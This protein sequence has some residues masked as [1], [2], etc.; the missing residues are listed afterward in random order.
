M[1]RL[2]S[3]LT[4][5]GLGALAM[6]FL[7]PQGGNRR[8]ALLRDQAIGFANRKQAAL[9]VMVTDF[10]NRAN[11]LMHEVQAMREQE[12]PDDQTLSER[13]RAAMGRHVSHPS[14][15]DVSSENGRVTLR[16]PILSDEVQGLVNA[17]SGVRG[18]QGVNNELEVHES[19]EGIPSLQGAS[20]RPVSGRMT[21]AACLMAGIGGAMLTLYGLGR[22]GPIGMVASAAGVSMIAKAFDDTERRFEPTDKVMISNKAKPTSGRKQGGDDNKPQETPATDD[23]SG[24]EQIEQLE[25][26]MKANQA[27][28]L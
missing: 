21:P 5:M 6:Y 23:G 16:G 3:M 26:A 2:T 10:R 18:V 25:S 27:S 8:Q 20:Y 11:G 9:D 1:S 13:V 24:I 28:A 22:R 12:D 7:D 19:P 15:I 4:N 14:A 17:V